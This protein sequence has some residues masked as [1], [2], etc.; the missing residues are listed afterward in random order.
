MNYTEFLNSKRK[1]II[2]SGFDCEKLNDHL[3]L[4][5]EFIVKRAL[6]AGKFAIFSDTG[7]GKTIMELEF[8]HQ[9]NIKTGKPVLI[10]APLA[11]SSQTIEEG[12]KFGIKVN[13]YKP[14]PAFNEEINE[15]VVISNYE[16][17]ENID[18]SIFSGIVLDESSILKNYSGVYKNMLID[19]F[20]KTPYKLCCTACPSPNDDLELGNHSEFL[21]VMSSQDMRSIFFTTEKS[22][23]D[24][25]KY[26]LKKHGVNEFFAW[27]NQWAVM[28]EKPSDLGFD[29]KGY[30][31][32]KLNIIERSV[33]VEMTDFK[34]GA[35]FKN[36]NVSATVFN[37][38][39]KDTVKERM[40]EVARIVNEEK[41]NETFLIWVNRDIEADE[42]K[43]LIPEAVEVR[44]SDTH[45]QKES[46]LLGFAKNQFRVLITK[47]KIAQYGLNF[48]YVRN[49]NMI[50]ASL[51]F[52]FEGTYQAMRR[53]YRF[54]QTNEVNAYLITIATMENVK[55]A[56]Q[57]KEHNFLR[58]RKAMVK[59]MNS[60]KDYSL[61]PI[62]R[63]EIKT[64]NYHVVLG[65][66]NEL[67]KEIPDGK[68]DFTF[69]SPPFN[70]IYVFSNELQDLSNCLDYETFMQH[71]EF[72][73]PELYRVMKSGRMVA[74][75]LMQLTT[76][77]GSDGYYS[78]TDFRGDVIR[79]FQ[80]H[81]FYFHAEITIR[82]DPQLVAVRT[83]NHQ[84]MWGTTK[85]NSLTVRPGLADYIVV[86]RKDKDV[87]LEEAVVRGIPFDKWCE[88]AEPVWMD[89][90]ESDTI[91]HRE[92]KAEDDER[93]ITA[94]QLEPI[95]RLLMMYTNKGD[96]CY[97]P[98]SGSGTEL[99]QFIKYDCKAIAHEL[100]ES[101]YNQSVIMA[102]SA[103]EEK[104]QTKMFE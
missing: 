34:N 18:C 72:I 14:S 24:G 53:M 63:K 45:E 61:K 22:R 82:K 3:F 51:D 41:P 27:V 85:K 67:I 65:D 90:N 16:Q 35:L 100:K 1:R 77:K 87:D 83:K 97:T 46:R 84:L 6:K 17:L 8:A 13:R 19:L 32:P 99:Y 64:D 76:L 36:T 12:V 47:K 92:A 4:F 37:A 23:A 96:T 42:L 38:E 79:M 54:G 43:R 30:D 25:N 70:S 75:H 60:N 81:G 59:M 98:F 80:K 94:T 71:F 50:F 28:I 56:I 95:K 49:A 68:V 93:H 2:E 86:M 66:S 11:V 89:V 62:Q 15:G 39:L 5:Q 44:G 33:S 26:R 29:N 104:T 9:V 55:K 103:A 102:R 7:T 57:E 91:K 58:M 101:Y 21:N 31:L 88:Y 48:Q 69:F 73:V 40:S 10:L 78:I 20:Q 74:M 52:S